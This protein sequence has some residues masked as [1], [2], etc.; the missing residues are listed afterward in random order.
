[1]AEEDDGSSAEELGFTLAFGGDGGSDSP[2]P[3]VLAAVLVE[4]QQQKPA[5]ADEEAWVSS[6]A[7]RKKTKKTETAP[8]PVAKPRAPAKPLGRG[9]GGTQQ[10]GG[11][12]VLAPRLVVAGAVFRGQVKAT[13]LTQG[14]FLR[15]GDPA[16]GAFCAKD[17]YA[18]G[19]TGLAVGSWHAVR[20]VRVAPGSGK[21]D[22]AVVG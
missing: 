22:L 8:L 14:A 16:S 2:S 19:A 11:P 13:A 4:P 20:V 12:G 18:R 15:F 10:R 21:I 17:G 1:L 6:L 7:G 9:G 5:A 3:M